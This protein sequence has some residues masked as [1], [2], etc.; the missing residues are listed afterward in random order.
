M[1]D[2]VSQAPE[3]GVTLGCGA[4]ACNT[5]AALH[6]GM[7]RI[8]SCSKV[9]RAGSKKPAARGTL[10]INHLAAE[11]QAIPLLA[12]HGAGVHRDLCH[13]VQAQELQQ[14]ASLRLPGE[15]SC[16]LL[17]YVSLA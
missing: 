14:M 10:D 13:V 1:Y 3:L 7:E 5:H 8:K 17:V 15:H 9:L 12:Q 6:Q 11:T 2:G 4:C 16:G